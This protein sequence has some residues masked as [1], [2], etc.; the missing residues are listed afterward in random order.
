MKMQ[1]HRCSRWRWLSSGQLYSARIWASHARMLG[2]VFMK[3]KKKT[4]CTTWAITCAHA[5]TV[6]SVLLLWEHWHLNISRFNLRFILF[7]FFLFFFTWTWRSHSS[8]IPATRHQRNWKRWCAAPI[9]CRTNSQGTVCVCFRIVNCRHASLDVRININYVDESKIR[10]HIVW[11]NNKNKKEPI[12]ETVEPV[13]PEMVSI[14]K[15]Q[16]WRTNVPTTFMVYG[17]YVF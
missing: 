2:Y 13:E 9:F 17:I 11:L 1:L 7:I 15:Y 3:A 16:L 14:S 12:R 8:E 6:S 10:E 4:Y 5:S